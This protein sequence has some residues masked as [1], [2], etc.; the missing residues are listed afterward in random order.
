MVLVD[1][2]VWIDLLQNPDSPWSARLAELITGYNR[3]AIC[4]IVLQEVLQ[5]IRDADA[6]ALTRERLCRLPFVDA[7]KDSSLLAADIYRQLRVKG[8]TVPS[9]DA[10]IAAIAIA[11]RM[12]LFSK[13]RHFAAI[14]AQTSLGIYPVE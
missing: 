14:A 5:G 10:A 11:N 12:E 9:T 13:D 8:I 6:Y 2:S 7:T 1:S 3:A 4:G